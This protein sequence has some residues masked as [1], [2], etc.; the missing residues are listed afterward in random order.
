MGKGGS[1]VLVCELQAVI[2]DTVPCLWVLNA[3]RGCKFINRHFP[4]E[5][6]ITA[7]G[8]ALDKESICTATGL[9][10]EAKDYLT[11]G[12]AGGKIRNRKRECH[13]T[14]RAGIVQGST[15]I[16]ISRGAG[17]GVP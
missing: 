16:N 17:I 4:D 6:P 10:L 11:V 2:V 7:I 1:S 5:C 15:T 9:D 13:A 14:N 3:I 8:A 12:D